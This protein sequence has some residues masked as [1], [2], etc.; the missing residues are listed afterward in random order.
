MEVA[1][2]QTSGAARDC[3]CAP[4]SI[5][6]AP[7][8]LPSPPDTRRGGKLY[9]LIRNAQQLKCFMGKELG[10]HGGATALCAFLESV[11]IPLGHGVKALPKSQVVT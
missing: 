6:W 7:G 8:H 5:N 1:V 3:G 11:S 2:A 4:S 10:H 9:F